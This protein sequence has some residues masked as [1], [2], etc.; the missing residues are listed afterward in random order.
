MTE[1]AKVEYVAPVKTSASVQD[2][3]SL[4]WLKASSELGKCVVTYAMISRRCS[5]SEMCR[6]THLRRI[7][8]LWPSG[9]NRHV[10]VD[11]KGAPENAPPLLQLR[12]I[13]RGCQSR[14]HLDFRIG[15][16]QP[17][18][19]HDPRGEGVS[20]YISQFHQGLG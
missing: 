11:T 19:A 8:E 16:I 18:Q 6:S 2:F 17:M 13:F 7:D 12:P 14:R 9:R 4:L 1:P 15:V 10:R 20:T 3:S 5:N